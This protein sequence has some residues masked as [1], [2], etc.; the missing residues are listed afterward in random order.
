MSW[1]RPSFP[2][3]VILSECSISGGFELTLFTLSLFQSRFFFDALR[4]KLPFNSE[5]P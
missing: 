4:E 5:K 2:F 3:K 1:L